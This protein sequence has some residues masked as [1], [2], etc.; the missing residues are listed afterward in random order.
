MPFSSQYVGSYNDSKGSI[1][2]I[3]ENDFEALSCWINGVRFYGRELSNLSVDNK[4]K[5]TDQQLE[6]FTF[7]AIPIHNTNK[8]EKV[9]CD[10]S[11]SFIVPQTIVDAVNN[12]NRDVEIEIG[13]FLGKQHPEIR[14]QHES[15]KY[16]LSMVLDERKY[17]GTSDDIEGALIQMQN[18]L[19]HKYF[20]KN[21]FGC[22]YGDYS[23]FGSCAFGSMICYS[24]QK[25]E[26]KGVSNKDEYMSLDTSNCKRVQEIYC[27]KEF[28]LRKIG[29][30]YRG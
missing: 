27:C 23:V 25:E 15:E 18:Q 19:N 30:G 5:Y 9:L 2:I 28:E 14:N 7:L 21:C 16:F 1:S 4:S 12:I 26:Y 29:V 13:C 24:N 22:M 6:R 8:V 20:F 3:V 11:F 10:C 17:F